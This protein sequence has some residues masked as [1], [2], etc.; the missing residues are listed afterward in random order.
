M[1]DP[2]DDLATLFSARQATV[3]GRE[4]TVRELTF[5][6]SMTIGAR[7]QPV[8]DTLLPHYGPDGAGVDSDAVIAALSANPDAAL[9]M[10]SLS[11]GQPVAW[12]AGLPEHDGTYLLLLCVAV[13]IPFFATRLELRHQ[14]RRLTVPT[15]AK[16][17]ARS[18]RGSSATGT[19]Q[20]H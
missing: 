15:V 8:I 16:A 7:L 20:A 19:R 13:H 11:T 12:L 3:A 1:S 5:T 2:A 17:S 6:Q 18:S 10:L 9:E 4:L 14:T